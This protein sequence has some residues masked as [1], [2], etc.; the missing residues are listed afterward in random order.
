MT[1]KQI[2]ILRQKSEICKEILW[3]TKSENYKK[4]KKKIYKYILT[5]D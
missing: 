2:K 1:S 5:L 3:L 4:Y